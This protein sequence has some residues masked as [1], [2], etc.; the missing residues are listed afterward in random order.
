MKLIDRIRKEY[1]IYDKDHKHYVVFFTHLLESLSKYCMITKPV[2]TIKKLVLVTIFSNLSILS[3]KIDGTYKQSRKRIND[4]Y[5][6]KNIFLIERSILLRWYIYPII[7]F[8][9]AFKIRK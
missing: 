2:F 1:M 6:I 3:H 9:L 4:H 8:I 5:K 7:C